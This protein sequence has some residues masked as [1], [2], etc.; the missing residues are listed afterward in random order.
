ML[1]APKALPF[2]Y[3]SVF[4]YDTF[5]FPIPKK[6]KFLSSHK[7]STILFS[8]NEYLKLFTNKKIIIIIYIQNKVSFN[9]SL[10][11]FLILYHFFFS[12][13]FL[14]LFDSYPSSLIQKFKLI[15]QGKFNYILSNTYLYQ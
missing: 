8:Y 4:L 15:D 11:V 5:V 13:S 12:C 10:F 9:S 2:I 14:V 3:P 1:L 6:Y 7:Y